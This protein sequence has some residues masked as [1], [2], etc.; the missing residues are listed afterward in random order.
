MEREKPAKGLRE[1]GEPGE[2]AL[3][4]GTPGRLPHCIPGVGPLPA[5]TIGAQGTGPCAWGSQARGGES[6]E[7]VV[8]RAVLWAGLPHWGSP[9]PEGFLEEEAIQAG[10]RLEGAL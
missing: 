7:S 10:L 8:L 3:S 6:P 5:R 2:R 9:G 1:E 4:R